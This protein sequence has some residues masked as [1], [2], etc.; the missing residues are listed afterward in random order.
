LAHA[1]HHGVVVTS[2]V[3]GF[4][5]GILSAIMN[6]MPTTLIGA[7]SIRGA[8]LVGVAHSVAV[9]ALV[10][11]ADIGPKFTPIGSL[12]TLLWLHVLDTKGIKITW[13]QYFRQGIV[14]AAP[15]LAITLL[16]LAGWI[17]V[18]H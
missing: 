16:A 3:G 8:H 17:L 12:A 7:L 10:V 14:L 1:S 5:A 18:L 13:G 6:N 2:L 15:V 4:G 11:G 9:Y